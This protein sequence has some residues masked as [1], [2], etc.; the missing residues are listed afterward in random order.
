MIAQR[1][2]TLSLTPAA[3]YSASLGYTGTFSGETF[4]VSSS[5]T[6]KATGVIIEPNDTTAGYATEKVTIAVL[7]SFD[8]PVYMRAGGAITKGAFVVQSTDGTIVTDP[9]SGARVIVGVAMAT[10]ATG[11]SVPVATTS[12]VYYAS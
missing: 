9:G 3:D 8:C 6:V 2:A 11:E 12:P 1:T 5:A 7:G 10:C 4:T